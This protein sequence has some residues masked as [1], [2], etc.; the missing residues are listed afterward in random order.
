MLAPLF[1]SF[2]LLVPKDFEK[3]LVF[4][5]FDFERT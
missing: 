4:Q 3:Y 5:P 1:S 2:D